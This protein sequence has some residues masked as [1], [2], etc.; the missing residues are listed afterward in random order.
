MVKEFLSQKGIAFKERDITRD[1]SAARELG[2]RTGRMAVPV[3]VI[4]GQTIIGFDRARLEQALGQVPRERPS[5]GAAVADAGKISPGAA[6]ADIGKVRPG[7]AAERLGLAPG[8][9]I[10]QLNMQ[11]VASADDLQY[12]L[13]KLERGSRFSIVFRRAMRLSVPKAASESPI[14]EKV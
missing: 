7:S 13:S 14:I 2:D 8:D 11:P 3:I 10:T 5:F 1:E 6:G 4:D 9:I 12:A